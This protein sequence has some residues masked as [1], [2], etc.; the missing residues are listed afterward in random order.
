MLLPEESKF[1]DV[2]TKHNLVLNAVTVESI[3]ATL[4]TTGRGKPEERGHAEATT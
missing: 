3:L 1:V 4:A 2:L